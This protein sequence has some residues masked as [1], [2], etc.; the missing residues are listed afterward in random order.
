MTEKRLFKD[1][2][3]SGGEGKGCPYM[4]DSVEEKNASKLH[5][6]SV[7]VNSQ[8]YTKSKTKKRRKITTEF[9]LEKGRKLPLIPIKRIET[10]LGGPL[11]L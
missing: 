2:L 1:R 5:Q 11:M 7:I 4:L 6:N 8:K 9:N 3:M 10:T